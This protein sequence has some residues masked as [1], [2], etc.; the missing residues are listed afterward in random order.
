MNMDELDDFLNNND[1]S[2][3]VSYNAK[4][5]ALDEKFFETDDNNIPNIENKNNYS[6][7]EDFLNNDDNS[8]PICYNA[9]QIKTV[10]FDEEFFETDDNKTT[11]I[12]NKNNYSIDE[13]FL[14]NDEVNNNSNSEVKVN[15]FLDD[16]FLVTTTD[17]EKHTKHK[18]NSEIS[19]K[20][21]T[22][23]GDFLSWL[24]TNDTT[25]NTIIQ[26]S[27]DKKEIVDDFFDEVFGEDI[28][29]SKSIT[30]SS[31]SNNELENQIQSIIS[32]SFPDIDQLKIICV[33]A[34]YVPR[35]FRGKIW[36]LLLTNATTEDEEAEFWRP[37]GNE[38]EKMKQMLLDTNAAIEQ[39]KDTIYEPSSMEQACIDMQE[40]ILL[41]C[42]RRKI[43]Y[44]SYFSDMLS[45][46]IVSPYPF[47]RAIASSCFYALCTEFV[48]YITLPVCHIQYVYVTMH[49]LDLFIYLCICLYIYT[50]II[51][52]SI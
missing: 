51:A 29:K 22:T 12:E 4:T 47:S 50:I 42:I 15:E 45:P 13:D 25:S 27:I 35:K 46:M 38:I 10:T 1:N 40:I 32:S 2:A 11:N 5:V 33:K 9:S 24:D 19:L 44:Q 23:D 34:G 16:S 20:N 41:Y 30:Y 28:L 37:N 21:N 18:N 8:A 31:G 48:S 49:L 14:N 43:E 36:N 3:P 52:C 17:T 7:D 39:V 26:S 6:I